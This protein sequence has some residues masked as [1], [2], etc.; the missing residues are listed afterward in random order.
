MSIDPIVR[1][2]G[3]TPRR[4]RCGT[5]IALVGVVA[6]VIF[7]LDAVYGFVGGASSST[8]S[9][10]TVTVAR[11]TV[12]SSVTASGNVSVARSAAAN[13]STSGTVTSVKVKV[14]DLV[15][16]G[17]RLATLDSAAAEANLETAKANLAQA[18]ATLASAQGGATAEQ[19]ASNA[20]SLHQAQVQVTTAEQQLEADKKALATAQQQLA[21][22]KKLNCPPTSSSSSAAS[23]SSVAV[24]LRIDRRFVS[25]VVAGDSLRGSKLGC[26]ALELLGEFKYAFG[27][28]DTTELRVEHESWS[29][30]RRAPPRRSALGVSLVGFGAVGVRVVGVSVGRLRDVRRGQW[31]RGLDALIDD[32]FE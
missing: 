7:A 15:T 1:R 24:E 29:V 26:F 6:V 25:D 28:V 31:W 3:E 8:G 5:A 19:Q 18:E 12:Q 2:L 10:R 30:D 20:S 21:D 17:Q 16:V 11:G 13:F 27:I 4:R 23:A 32:R 9:Q 22:S 14:G